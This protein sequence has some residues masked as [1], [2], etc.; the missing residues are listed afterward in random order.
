M[1]FRT[2][3]QIVEDH[4]IARLE[5]RDEELLDIGAEAFAVDRPVEQ[6]GRFDPVI[7][8]SGKERRGFPLALRDLVEKALSLRRPAREAGS[9]WSWSTTCPRPCAHR[10]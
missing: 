5:G 8:K 10:R 3:F 6:A 1:A 2:V 9:C 4:S 7:A